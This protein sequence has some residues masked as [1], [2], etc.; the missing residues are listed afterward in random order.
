MWSSWVAGHSLE[1]VHAKG[2]IHAW[3]VGQE[4]SEGRLLKQAE[5][6]DFVPGGTGKERLDLEHS[7]HQAPPTHRD[8]D[9]H[10]WTKTVSDQP[11]M[12][13]TQGKGTEAVGSRGSRQ[14]WRELRYAE[15]I[16]GKEWRQRE[17][18]SMVVLGA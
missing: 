11:T 5:D 3:A 14:G 12:M 1:R 13:Y 8:R 9:G 4:G 6:Q 16:R 7:P 18:V 15:K 17:T 10:R 2:H